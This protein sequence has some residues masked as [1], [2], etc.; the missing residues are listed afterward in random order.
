MT[1]GATTGSGPAVFASVDSAPGTFARP[2]P[3]WRAPMLL[4]VFCALSAAQI[5]LLFHGPLARFF[6]AGDYILPL[7]FTGGHAIGLRAFSVTFLFCF[8]LFWG[9]DNATRIRLIADL[10]PTYAIICLSID[11]GLATVASATGLPVPL[12]LAEILSGLSGWALFAL[13]LLEH[14]TLPRA[15]AI[16]RH[17]DGFRRNLALAAGLVIL[18]VLGAQ[19][20]EHKA[21]G[22]VRTLRDGGIL[23]GLGPGVFL[24]LPLFFLLLYLTARFMRRDR[25]A[26]PGFSPDVT[27]IVPAFNEEYII[28]RT[29]E[30]LDLAARDY[31]GRVHVLLI[32]NNSRDRTGEIATTTF[33][34]C[35]NISGRV[36]R[37]GTPGKAHAL[38][39]GLR[40]TETDLLIRVDADTQILPG[41][42]ARAVSWFAHPRTGV[43]GGLPMVPGTGPFDGARQIETLVKHGF[44]SVALQSIN[45]VVGVPGMLAVYRT[46][47]IRDLGGF[48][49]GMN[50]EDTDISM[51]IGEMGY[52][53][54]V[55]PKIRYISEVPVS[56]THLREQRLR[57]FRSVL[58]VSSRCRQ[59]ILSD[60]SS[61]R[62]R[63]VLP[64]MLFN[65]ARRTAMIPLILFGFLEYLLGSGSRGLMEWQPLIAVMLGASLMVAVLVILISGLPALLLAL[66]DYVA[67]RLLRSYFTLESMLTIRV[68]AEQ[69][70]FVLPKEIPS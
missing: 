2:L 60:Q 24:V 17:D 20:V 3:L 27:V 38:N 50:G 10:L 51:R 68:A 7:G 11:L 64:Y 19:L 47:L 34:A 43:V 55:D 5:V 53:I 54:V 61:I 63:L 16:R 8:A 31:G 41:S 37:E 29:I 30:A 28:A 45:G 36:I 13:R 69:R 49:S 35:A 66:P 6:P 46:A 32:D 48:V 65:S 25:S 26:N 1:A 56:F 12:H 39:T 9:R 14:A 15:I 57:W 44:Y 52:R 40:L 22:L 21:A 18:A 23:G 67:F 33:A 70:P 42:I 59:V 4:L 58:H 62:G